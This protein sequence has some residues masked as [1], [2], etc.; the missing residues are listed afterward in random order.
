MRRYSTNYGGKGLH[1]CLLDFAV[2]KQLERCYRITLGYWSSHLENLGR[3]M[4]IIDQLYFHHYLFQQLCF[5]SPYFM[6]EIFYHCILNKELDLKFH[7][8]LGCGYLL[9]VCILCIFKLDVMGSEEQGLMVDL[10]LITALDLIFMVLFII[11][12]LIFVF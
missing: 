5:C 8:L 11:L 6:F 1:W 7:N 2:F 10:S 4:K 3:I 9:D 12:T